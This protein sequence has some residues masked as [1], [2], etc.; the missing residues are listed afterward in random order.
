MG[1]RL[2]LT[3]S[4]RRF[5][6]LQEPNLLFPGVIPLHIDVVADCKIVHQLLSRKAYAYAQRAPHCPGLTAQIGSS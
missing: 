4:P 2:R 6:S 1:S 5:L 3:L